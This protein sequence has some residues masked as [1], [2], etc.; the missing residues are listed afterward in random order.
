[1]NALSTLNALRRG[2]GPRTQV[3]LSETYLRGVRLAGAF[4]EG[5]N[6]GVADLSRSTLARANL[7]GANLQGAFLREANLKGAVVINNEE[8]AEQALSLEG[9]T[10]PDG[11][12]HS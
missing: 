9:A 11:S 5:A 1:V 2:P 6:L 4:L 12:E 7:Q 10:M 3:D 8:L